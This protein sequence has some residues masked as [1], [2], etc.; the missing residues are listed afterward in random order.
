MVTNGVPAPIRRYDTRNL[1]GQVDGTAN[2]AAGS[3]DLDELVWVT[4]GPDWMNGGTYLATRRIRMMLTMWDRMSIGVQEA[5]I[6]RRRDTGA[7]LTGGDEF[8]EPD[9][10]ATS[11]GA[12]VIAADAHVRI[13][14]TAS[15]GMLRRE[16]SY[17][18]GPRTTGT[19]P[20]PSGPMDHGQHGEMDHSATMAAMDDH[21]ACLFFAAYI[22]DPTNP[23]RPHA[24]GAQRFRRTRP[25]PRLHL[26]RTVGNPRRCRQRSDRSTT[27]HMTR[28]RTTPN[29]SGDD[30]T[31]MAKALMGFVRDF[32]LLQ[33][34]RTPCGKPLTVTQAHALASIA[35]QPGFTQRDLGEHLGL[36]RATTSE[37]VTQLANRG[38]IAQRP[39]ADDRR[40]RNIDLTPAGRRI[41]NEIGRARQALMNDLLA[42]LT[43][44]DRARLVDATELLAN[45]VHQRRIVSVPPG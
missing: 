40:Q 10:D 44:A 12:P 14:K 15:P 39:H 27:L 4:D 25:L 8:T 13:A 7:P 18:N 20:A 42:D 32:G 29:R 2:P 34:D 11:D 22:R 33:P 19:S 16:Y 5:T 3:N 21:D 9:L 24:T 43:P 41:T 17:D 45:T 23:I 31:R 28:P 6:G 38:W 36:A 37:L 26:R 1:F 30:A 35:A